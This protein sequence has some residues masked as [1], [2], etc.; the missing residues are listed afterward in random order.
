MTHVSWTEK[1]C[2]MTSSTHI[3]SLWPKGR[4]IWAAIRGSKEGIEGRGTGY[5][6]DAELL[7]LLSIEE[8]ESDSIQQMD[9][10]FSEDGHGDSK[11]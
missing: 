7:D 10:R 3:V 8:C 6:L 4:I 11:R 2:L 9:G 1:A 5:L